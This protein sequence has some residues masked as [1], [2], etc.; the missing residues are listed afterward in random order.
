MQIKNITVHI[1]FKGS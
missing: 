1:D